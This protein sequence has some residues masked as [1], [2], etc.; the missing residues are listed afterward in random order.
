ML[1]IIIVKYYLWSSLIGFQG[2]WNLKKHVLEMMKESMSFFFAFGNED[3]A[4]RSR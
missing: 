4:K 3:L 1:P 2:L